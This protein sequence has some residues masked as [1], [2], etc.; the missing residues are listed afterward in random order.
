MVTVSFRLAYIDPMEHESYILRNKRCILWVDRFYIAYATHDKPARY[1]Y[2]TRH[3]LYEERNALVN[4]KD[5]GRF[6]HHTIKFHRFFED[7]YAFMIEHR[8]EIWVLPE[9]IRNLTA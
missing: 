8:T 6:R 9:F 3:H 4:T 5:R 2:L 7:G 1:F